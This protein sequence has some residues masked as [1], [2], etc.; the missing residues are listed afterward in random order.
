LE[1]GTGSGAVAAAFSSAVRP[2][3]HRFS[4]EIRDD[5]G[6][7]ARRNLVRLGL[8][9]YVAFK[10]RDI[11]EGLYETDVDA[12]FLDVPAPW[13]YVDEA[14][15]ALRGSGLFG[16]ILPT[17]NQV[18]HLLWAW[19]ARPLLWS[20]SRNSSCAAARQLPPACGRWI[21]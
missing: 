9:E 6:A 5:F 19:D 7:I 4:H 12:P 10:Q 20:K 3:G 15:A 14:H 16:S 17:A 13:N 21:A 8:Q 2:A 11:A 1:A 18:I